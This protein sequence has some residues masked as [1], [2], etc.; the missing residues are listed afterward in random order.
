MAYLIFYRDVLQL[1]VRN[2]TRVEAITRDTDLGGFALR[3]AT[4]TGAAASSAGGAGAS[5]VGGEEVVFARKVV[6]AT[7]IQVCVCVCASGLTLPLRVCLYPFMPPRAACTCLHAPPLTAPPTKAKLLAA[8]VM[9][10]DDTRV[11]CRAAGSGT[12]RRSS[13]SRCRRTCMRT[14]AP[15]LTLPRCAASGLLC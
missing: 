6:L 12:C 3:L 10:D 14:R 5:G 11:C 2:C 9:V 8:S 15:T 1:P 4:S 13:Q 7:G